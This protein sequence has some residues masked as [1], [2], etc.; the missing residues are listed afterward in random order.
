MP[1]EEFEFWWRN[2]KKRWLQFPQAQKMAAKAAWDAVEEKLTAHNSPMQKFPTLEE[3]V[4]EVR[5]Y[6]MAI[7]YNDPEVISGI[8]HDFIG[9][10]LSA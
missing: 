3:V 8:V 1:L 4:N 5:S 9:R 7:N 2:D 6:R 10:K